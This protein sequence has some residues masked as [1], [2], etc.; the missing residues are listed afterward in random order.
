MREKRCVY[1]KLKFQPSLRNPSQRVCSSPQCQGRRRADYHR[2]KLARDSDY[3]DEC[4]RSRKK[5]RERNAGRIK[6]YDEEYRARRRMGRIGTVRRSRLLKEVDRLADLVRNSQAVEVQTFGPNIL[7]IWPPDP[8]GA[9]ARER[10][11]WKAEAIWWRASAS[12]RRKTE[13][14]QELRD[15]PWTEFCDR[16]L[17]DLTGYVQLRVIARILDRREGAVR[18][19][20][21]TLSKNQSLLRKVPLDPENTPSSV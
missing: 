10:C 13:K 18:R 9:P 17:L 5:W 6:Q 12:C 4:R 15:Y 21:V 14:R 3:R 2:K 7:L 19:R 16:T 8:L 20:L 1:C 11:Q